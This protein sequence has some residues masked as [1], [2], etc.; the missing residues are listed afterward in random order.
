MKE[1]TLT[2]GVDIGG[3]NTVV[4]VVDTDGVCLHKTSIAMKDQKSAELFMRTLSSTINELCRNLPSNKTICGIG[5]A[6]PAARHNKG[7]VKNPANLQWGTVNLVEMMG[8][9]FDV[10]IAITNDS[11]AAALGELKCGLAQGKKNFITLT[12][13]TGL[14]AGIVVEGALLYGHNSMAGELGHMTI[15]PQ[16][17]RCGCG[18]RGC[19]ETYVSASGVCRTVFELLEKE[20]DPTKLRSFCYDNLTSLQVFELAQLGDPVAIKAFNMTGDY[21]GRMIANTVA[22]FDPELVILSGGLSNAEGALLV[23]TKKAF[24]EN[25]LEWHKD[26]VVIKKSHLQNAAIIGASAMMNEIIRNGH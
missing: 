16:G 13:G 8:Q 22:A 7:I 1:A 23:P 18:R 6:A 4:G 25:A 19:V 17:R 2:I 10:P 15:E 3:T 11:N 20:T 14:G 5:I 24:E 12:L 26:S 9:Y 21:L